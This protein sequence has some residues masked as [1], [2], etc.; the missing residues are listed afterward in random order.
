MRIKMYVIY[1]KEYSDHYAYWSFASMLLHVPL[2][3]CAIINTANIG[4]WITH[5]SILERVCPPP[6]GSDVW[7]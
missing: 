2:V 1:C 7:P 5:W 3:H 6:M 4:I